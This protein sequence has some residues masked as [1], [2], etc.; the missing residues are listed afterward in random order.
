M[1]LYKDNLIFRIVFS[2]YYHCVFSLLARL[3]SCFSFAVAFARN[4]GKIV[5]GLN[6]KSCLNW[7]CLNKETTVLQKQIL[8]SKYYHC[9]FSLLA[10]LSSCFSFAVAFARNSGKWLFVLRWDDLPLLFFFLMS[11]GLG[12]FLEKGRKKEFFNIACQVK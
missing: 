1:I 7:T 9:A 8:F 3:S 6:Q 5:L 2:K 12:P 4:S 11:W 10:R